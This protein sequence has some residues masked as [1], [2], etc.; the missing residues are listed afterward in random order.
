MEVI[1]IMENENRWHGYNRVDLG[2][3]NTEVWRERKN[4][5]YVGDWVQLDD[6]GYG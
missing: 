5:W 1:E 2:V 3:G 6:S 4:K